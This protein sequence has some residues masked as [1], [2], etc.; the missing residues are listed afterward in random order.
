MFRLR[1]DLFIEIN[2]VIPEYTTADMGETF[3]IELQFYNPVVQ[4]VTGFTELAD[5]EF[6]VDGRAATLLT[7]FKH[8]LIGG[9][10]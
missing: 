6:T 1:P 4:F 3:P 8:Q 5:D 7:A 9:G 2:Y 10:V